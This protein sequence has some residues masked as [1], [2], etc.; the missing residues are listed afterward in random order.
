MQPREAITSDSVARSGPRF[1]DVLLGVTLIGAGIV[2]QVLLVRVLPMTGLGLL[3]SVPFGLAWTFA[4]AVGY[5]L[6]ATRL[7][8]WWARL[9]AFA[10]F[11]SA[12][13]FQAIAG[14]PQDYGGT[15]FDKLWAMWVG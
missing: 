4:F 15:T 9:L 1:S 7:Q 10:F 6:V 8:R 12:V 5:F 14:H 3:L 13:I 11:L 2:V